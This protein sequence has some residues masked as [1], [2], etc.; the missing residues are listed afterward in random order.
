MQNLSERLKEIAVLVPKN[1]RVADIGTDHGYL[2]IYLIKNGIASY[3]YACD[4]AEK[5][6]KSAQK[7][8]EVSGLHNIEL[9]LSDGLENV[10][11]D[12]IDTAV[13]AGMGG[14]VILGILDR[15]TW[16]KN[17]RYTVVLQPTT[18]PEKLR[19]FLAE[20][21][22]LVDTEVAVCENGKIY[23]IMRVKFSGKR[24]SLRPYELFIGKLKPDN[25]SATAYIQKQL[26]RVSALSSDLKNI[27]AK[28]EEYIYYSQIA[29]TL[30]KILGGNNGA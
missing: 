1:C 3:C 11:P 27:S 14:E 5:P 18:S 7:N 16:I 6:L 4:I 19:S 10:A 17:D 23:S 28:R 9:R 29:D 24:R 13:I 25:S 8:I 26:K 12:E 20:N 15:C 22:F 2:P 30:T 21:G